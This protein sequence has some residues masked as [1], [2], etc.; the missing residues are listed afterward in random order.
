MDVVV[1][2]VVV[3]MSMQ[4]VS[5][6]GVA[7]VVCSWLA[8]QVVTDWHAQ[9]PAAALNVAPAT[10]AEQTRSEVAVAACASPCPA[11]QVEVAVQLLAPVPS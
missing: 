4:R 10:H 9:L 7:T 11:A 2:D 1:V 8:A 3:V 5:L 6:V